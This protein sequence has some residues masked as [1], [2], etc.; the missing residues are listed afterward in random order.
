MD[1][2]SYR[3]SRRFGLWRRDVARLERP[4]A[5]QRV[6]EPAPD[7]AMPSQRSSSH[8]ERERGRSVEA[9]DGGGEEG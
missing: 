8:R 7:W 9:D 5:A 4:R 3:A 1:P 2:Y 6:D